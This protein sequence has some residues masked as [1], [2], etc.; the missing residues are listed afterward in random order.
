[1]KGLQT[2]KGHCLISVRIWIFSCQYFPTFGILTE[3]R[4]ILCSVSFRIQSE[5]GKIRT[6]KTPNTDTFHAVG[7]INQRLKWNYSHDYKISSASAVHC[8]VFTRNKIW[9]ESDMICKLDISY[10]QLNILLRISRLKNFENQSK[11][12][13]K[14]SLEQID[15]LI[16]FVH[17]FWFVHLNCP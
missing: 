17:Q 3:Y 8:K 10:S 7:Y 15:W 11:I 14:S 5:C 12:T 4:D 16:W 13:R 1:M 6:R 9:L 2:K